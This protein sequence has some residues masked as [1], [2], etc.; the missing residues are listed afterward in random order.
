MAVELGKVLQRHYD[1]GWD[2]VLPLVSV[3]GKKE[4]DVDHVMIK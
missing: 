3:V 4:G 1:E 2:P